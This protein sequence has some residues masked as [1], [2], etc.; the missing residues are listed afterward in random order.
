MR[1]NAIGLIT[2]L[3][4]FLA[5]AWQGY[6]EY[7]RRQPPKPVVSESVRP[8]YWN[9]GRHWFCRVGQQEYIWLPDSERLAGQQP[10]IR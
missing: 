3:L 1:G 9:D 2:A 7:L 6:E 8:V 10:T 4:S 5:V